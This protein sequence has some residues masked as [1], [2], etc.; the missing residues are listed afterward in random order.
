MSVAGVRVVVFGC[1]LFVRPSVRLSVCPPVTLMY[2]GRIDRISSKIVTPVIAYTL[3]SCTHNI[4]NLVQWD[5]PQI[6]DGIG[7]GLLFLSRK[8]DVSL[9]LGKIGPRLLLTTNRKLHTHF[10]LVPKSATLD[11][12][13]RPLHTLRCRSP[14]RKFE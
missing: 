13:E 10:R 7:V 3:R 6:S 4:G 11:D 2:R 5:H 8:P 14:P 9:K 12:L 1:K